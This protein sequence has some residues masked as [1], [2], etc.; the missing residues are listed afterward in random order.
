MRTSRRFE[1]LRYVDSGD[2]GRRGL[3]LPSDSINLE[4]QLFPD[5]LTPRESLGEG[6]LFLE[7]G[8]PQTTSS[9]SPFKTLA[10]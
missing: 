7:D 2:L 10:A 3:S 5:G 4:S 1:I 8:S 6:V 9:Q